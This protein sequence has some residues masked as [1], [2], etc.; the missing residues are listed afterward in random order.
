MGR[1]DDDVSEAI[2]TGS[3]EDEKNQEDLPLGMSSE[4]EPPQR[5]SRDSTDSRY[6][7]LDAV[8]SYLKDIR[9]STLLNFEE[10]Q[11]LGKR[12]AKGDF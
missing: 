9:K 7:G 5:G 6:E 2:G 12:I 4:F 3:E 1:D 11:E 8:K 10:E